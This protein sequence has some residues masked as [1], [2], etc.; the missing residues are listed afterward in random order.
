MKIVDEV[1]NFLNGGYE[2]I[3]LEIYWKMEKVVENME[4]EKVVEY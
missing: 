4:F 2:K 1:K 3:E